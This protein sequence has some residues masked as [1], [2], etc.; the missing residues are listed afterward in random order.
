MVACEIHTKNKSKRNSSGL[1][2]AGYYNTSLS[3][4]MKEVQR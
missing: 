1:P 4:V 3:Y 2:T